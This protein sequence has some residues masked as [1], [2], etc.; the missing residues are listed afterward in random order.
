M[1]TARINE[2]SLKTAP[3]SPI[4]ELD[5]LLRLQDR[6]LHLSRLAT[7]GEMSTGIAHELNQPLC[8]V[9]N[10]AQACD[11]LLGQPDPDLREIRDC[12]KQIASQAL[13]AGDVIRRLRGLARPK[14]VRR[15]ATDINRLLTELTELIQSDAKHHQVR[16][17]VEL[18]EELPLVRADQAEIQQLVLSL[19]RNAIEALAGSPVTAREVNISTR[20]TEN[21]DV[22]LCVSDRGPGVPAV[23][24]PR[25]FT[26]FST[27]KPS[28]TGLGLAMSRTIAQAHGGALSYQPNVPQGACFTLTLPAVPNDTAQ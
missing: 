7:V 19:V 26:A 6:L 2:G 20:R 27:T 8:A 11:R 28:G 5:A 18:G 10:Y 21:G 13:R 3:A 25:L 23:I 14:E 16:Y 24:A 15:E 1:Q 22:A 12:L 17:C 4:A 9:A